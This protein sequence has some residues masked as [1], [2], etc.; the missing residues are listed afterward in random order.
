MPLRAAD[1]DLLDV[2]L[3]AARHAAD[4]RA[5][6]GRIA[7]AEHGQAFFAHD[8]LHDAFA[9]QARVRL[10]GQEGHAHAVLAGRRQGEAQP[11]ALAR[12]ELVRDLDE[13]AGAVAGFRVAAAGAAMGQVDQNLDALDDDVVRLAGL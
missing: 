4:G 2:R 12:E 9:L 13:H 6:D 8:A 10:H 7:P 3:R 5:V 1:E 11:G